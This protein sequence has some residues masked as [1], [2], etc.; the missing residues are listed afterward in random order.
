MAK[1]VVGVDFGHRA[2]RAVEVDNPVGTSGRVVRSAEV[3]VPDTAIVDGEVREV[4]TV[5]SALKRLWSTGGFKTKRVVLGMGNSRVLARDLTVPS[6]PLDQIRETLPFQA[7]DLLPVPSAGAILDFYPI[8]HGMGENGAV[9]NGL[10]I[11]ALKDVVL[12]NV[13]AVRTAGL[14]TVG[15]DLIPF[16]LTRLLADSGGRET[17]GYIDVGATTT[18]V[19]IATGGVPQF[20]RIIP[21][22]GEDVTRALVERAEFTHEQAERAKVVLG[23]PLGPVEADQRAVADIIVTEAG[24]LLTGLRNTLN[25]FV[26]SRGT[27]ISRVVVTGGGAQLRGF[28]NALS[29]MT[30][31]PAQVAD[32]ASDTRMTVALS[33]AKGSTAA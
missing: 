3:T 28:V 26:S 32:P 5:A 18:S 7:Q 33:L 16:S 24:Q 20:V 21:A 9:V 1:R 22:G 27:A 19:T 11:A 10:L 13:S 31:L 12:A 15:V 14:E 29:E 2:I 6:M 23:I 17:V 8:S 4:H 30:Q 25:Y